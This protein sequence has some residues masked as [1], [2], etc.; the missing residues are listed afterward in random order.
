MNLHIVISGLVQG[1]GYRQWLREKALA[2]GLTGWVRNR[3]DGTVEAIVS[4]PPETVE[5][6]A[7]EARKGPRGARV[8]DVDSREAPASP[9]GH[10]SAD[11]V[12][13]RSI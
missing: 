11:F 7:A 10:A 9:A 8:A 3:A 6:L 13:A 12:I 4:G 1:V 5:A 2:A